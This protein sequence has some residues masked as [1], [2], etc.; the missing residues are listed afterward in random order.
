M[1]RPDSGSPADSFPLSALPRIAPIPGRRGLPDAADR[2]QRWVEL[3][4]SMSTV[5][6]A[7]ASIKW[8]ATMVRFRPGSFPQG[9]PYYPG[10][11]ALV[12]V[13]VL[14]R[15]PLAS[16]F[17]KSHKTA[18]NNCGKIEANQFAT[19]IPSA[20]VLSLFNRSMRSCLEKPINKLARRKSFELLDVREHLV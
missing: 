2:W 4:H 20:D 14:E 5:G 16:R 11:T 15:F 17:T 7:A 12:K 1:V 6:S 19:S 10:M 8:N 9:E 3:H 18:R 13:G